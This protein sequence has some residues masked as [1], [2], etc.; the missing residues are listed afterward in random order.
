MDPNNSQP[1]GENQ[2]LNKLE[3]DLDR[4]TKEAAATT[5]PVPETPIQT[6]Q[7]QPV[8][9]QPMEIPSPPAE[10]V[11][12]PTQPIETPPAPP[13]V[14]VESGKKGM[15]LM[16]VAMTLLIIAVVVA[17]GYVAYTK[18]IAPTLSPTVVPIQT[19]LPTEIPMP[20]ITPQS[21]PSATPDLTANWKTY[22]NTKD[23]FSFKYPMTWKEA[24]GSATTGQNSREFRIQTDKSEFINGIVFD[25][26]DK[27]FTEQS[28]SKQI[29][30]SSG[31]VVLITYTDNIGPGSQGGTQDIQLFTQI[32]STFKL[33]DSPP[34]ATPQ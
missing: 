30:I 9:P 12:V 1:T 24:T 4:L 14:P 23:G 27:T 8:P 6:P 10:P 19:S 16:T 5:Q 22:S 26:A 34:S 17:V 25:K 11:N 20:I 3:E 15:S 29:E 28:W 21:S 13:N 32:L 31:K 33:T 2:N 18:F 7:E